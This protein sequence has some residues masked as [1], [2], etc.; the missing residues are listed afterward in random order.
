MKDLSRQF[1]KGVLEL[2][3]LK[4]LSQQEYYGYQ[5]IQE[6]SKRSENSFALKEG[7][8]YPILYRLEDQ[9]MVES[10]WLE[11]STKSQRKKPKKYYKITE[12]GREQLRKMLLSWLEFERDVNRVLGS[13]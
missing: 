1:K 6:L 4:L 2:L 8:L 11:E 10:Y 3:V 13:F 5:L 7:T 12:E 9:N